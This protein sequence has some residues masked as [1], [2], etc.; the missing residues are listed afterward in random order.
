MLSVDIPITAT[1]RRNTA[2]QAAHGARVR[3]LRRCFIAPTATTATMESFLR[4]LSHTVP[5]ESIHDAVSTVLRRHS[6]LV[7]GNGQFGE[8]LAECVTHAIVF[9]SAG[10]IARM[11][12]SAHAYDENT[13]AVE[14]ES[15][16]V[17]CVLFSMNE[18]AEAVDLAAFQRTPPPVY[19]TQDGFYS[20][21]DRVDSVHAAVDANDTPL[22]VPASLVAEGDWSVLGRWRCVYCGSGTDTQ[23]VSCA[24]GIERGCF[25]SQLCAEREL[26]HVCAESSRQADMLVTKMLDLHAGG[27]TRVATRVVA[28]VVACDT[29]RLVVPLLIGDAMEH[30]MLP[31]HWHAVGLVQS[32]VAML[33]RVRP[34]AVLRAKRAVANATQA[35][36][37]HSLGAGATP[38]RV[39]E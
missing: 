3:M 23:R 14:L 13:L 22:H 21:L 36:H 5:S 25:C 2:T 1:F 11:L 30:T 12:T 28:P 10:E 26:T 18:T 29:P 33:V 34:L 32:D 4:L 35:R 15:T 6:T 39:V 17:S 27:T 38:E 16:L 19:T 24:C 8:K 37:A 31:V 9:A 7:S 20:W